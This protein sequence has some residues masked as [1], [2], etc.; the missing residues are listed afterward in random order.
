MLMGFFSGACQRRRM[1]RRSVPVQVAQVTRHIS[2]YEHYTSP[3]P[4]LPRGTTTSISMN[5]STDITVYIYSNDT[6]TENASLYLFFYHLLYNFYYFY[7]SMLVTPPV[8]SRISLSLCCLRR[9]RRLWMALE[10]LGSGTVRC[11]SRRGRL[12]GAGADAFAGGEVYAGSIC[13]EAQGQSKAERSVLFF[14]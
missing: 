7:T 9:A 1:R 5:P 12:L 8:R 10:A 11:E 4:P 14:L 6:W 3:N 2:P 13:R